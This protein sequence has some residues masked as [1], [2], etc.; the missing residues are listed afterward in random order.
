MSQ[1]VVLCVASA[2]ISVNVADRTGQKVDYLK[3]KGIDDIYIRKMIVE[4]LQKF[5]EAKKAD[6]EELLLDKI[7]DALDEKQKKDKI[8]NILQSMRRANII[9]NF[10][11]IWRLSKPD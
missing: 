5:R 6:F 4:L 1:N 10:G 8:K 9:N 2:S 11:K 7:S 3:L